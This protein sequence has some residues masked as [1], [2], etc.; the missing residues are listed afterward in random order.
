[1]A[2][3][4]PASPTLGQ[5]YSPVQGITYTYN[6]VGWVLAANASPVGA[7]LIQRID[8]A[9]PV[10][11][12]DFTT[13]INAIY[14]EYELH[15]MG[16]A[17]ATSGEQMAIRISTD[18]GA[19]WKA[20]AS[21]YGFAFYLL[22]TNAAGTNS[23]IA[24]TTRIVPD[25][26]SNTTQ[27]LV[28]HIKFARPS[29]AQLQSFRGHLSGWSSTNGYY[30][31]VGSGF[32][33][34]PEAINGIRFF[35][36][37]GSNI[38][39]GTFILYGIK[40]IQPAAVAVPSGGRV[41]IQR[42]DV[43]AAVAAVNFTSGIDATYDEYVLEFYGFYPATEAGLAM[44]ISNNGGSSYLG[45]ANYQYGWDLAAAQGSFTMPQTIAATAFNFGAGLPANNGPGNGTVRL[46]RPWVSNAPKTIMWDTISHGSAN[47]IFRATGA[48]MYVGNTAAINAFR[49]LASNGSNITAGTFILYGIK[50]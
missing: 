39:Q 30:N 20:G 3:D 36:A 11:T 22:P 27:P 5:L 18:G 44:Q 48:A 25:W 4:F 26:G 32:Y 46:W 19:T 7:T 16:V 24:L 2:F 6:G 23:C 34:N 41:L 15:L 47:S 38:A 43:A 12:V 42:Q 49:L 13:G 33:N 37:G 14:E 45:D 8:V 17:T 9:A 40:P 21:D 28:G 50:K 10:A 31:S 1:M 29:V 35:G